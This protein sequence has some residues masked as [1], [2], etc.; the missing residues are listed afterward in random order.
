[1]ASAALVP[2][3][4]ALQAG[5]T[6]NYTYHYFAMSLTKKQADDPGFD[7]KGPLTSDDKSARPLKVIRL[8]E[9]VS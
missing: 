7:R 4:A 9:L 3:I 5:Q 1:M 2:V 6:D 8:S